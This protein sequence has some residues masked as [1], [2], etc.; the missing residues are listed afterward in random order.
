VRLSLVTRLALSGLASAALAA[1]ASARAQAGGAVT[2]S[3]PFT[4]PE[5]APDTLQEFDAAW[6]IL[7]DNYVAE[8]TAHVD[9]DTL[10]TELRPRAEKARSSEEVRSLIREIIDRIGQ[11]HFAIVPAPVASDLG[12]PSLPSEEI[13]S[14]GF[15]VVPIEGQLIVGRVDA[16]G[17]AAQ[18]GVKP[19][20]ALERV[21]DRDVR[22]ALTAAAEGPDSG[23]AFR[24]W[25][26]GTSLL[27][28][29]T[30]VG[31]DLEFLD[32]DGGRV[33]CQ[34]IRQ[35]ARGAA[36]KFGHLPMLFAH[37]DTHRVELDG[38]SV[39]VVAFNV[40]MTPVAPEL[41]RAIEQFRDA[42]G[43][44]VD[45]RGNP[46]GVLTM[47]M[48]F[49]G[50]FLDAP[51]N[52]GTIRT[53]DSDLNLVANPRL[54]G[55]TGQTVKPFS[56]PVAILVDGGSYSASEIFAGGMQSIHRARVFGNR[57]AGGA[58]P[59]VLERLPGGDV[60]QYAIGDFTTA[61]GDRI[62]GNG[63]V[64]DVSVSPTRADLL[65]GRDPALDAAVAW[66]A[67]GT[68]SR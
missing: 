10:R 63:V 55:P 12:G 50:H 34:V 32:G 17:P 18:V 8:N 39:G 21:G 1:P 48:G 29:R 43:I 30:G 27:R 16:N 65:A 62:E 54:V 52:L 40:W 47:I 60:L 42:S 6:R 58:L 38:R 68:E 53:R 28:G 37:V 33:T 9:W 2:A 45:L 7:R 15:D 57:T 11:S 51:V 19:G 46:G 59:A 61:T 35:P 13:G 14:L 23:R 66:V 31:A 44:V 67:K 26:V 24:T 5:H 22:S 36:V 64:P 25:A 3:R 56:G 49:A 41:D 4:E 20:W